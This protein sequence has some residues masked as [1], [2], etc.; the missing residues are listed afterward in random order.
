M[1]SVSYGVWIRV[2]AGLLIVLTAGVAVAQPRGRDRDRDRERDDPFRRGAFAMSA[3]VS[4]LQREVDSLRTEVQ[5]AEEEY[6][7]AKKQRDAARKGLDKAETT[8]RE[9]GR[10]LAEVALR[11][12]ETEPKDSTFG[13]AREASLA[14][15]A[16]YEAAVAKA[17]NA[18]EYQA[19]YEQAKGAVDRAG[20]VHELRKQWIDGNPTVAEASARWRS[21]RSAYETL[22]D[23]LFH[24]NAE[25]E[26]AA[27][28]LA[29]ARR[30][31]DAAQRSP[32]A[33][34]ATQREGVAKRKLAKLEATLKKK[35]EQLDRLQAAERQM[36]PSDMR[37]RDHRRMR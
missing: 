21:A 20:A 25:W 6:N 13:R 36:P 32:E 12:E 35:A 4:D 11:V 33:I 17:E 27:K 7:A 26:R 24:K 5:K 19:A 14:A 28:E 18:A 29:E 9:A 3:Q 22:R 30:G 23:V 2:T 31:R 15:R 37:D 34:A 10:R 1:S 8:A 16:A